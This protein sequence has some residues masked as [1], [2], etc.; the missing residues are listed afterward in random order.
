M[1]V[2]VKERTLECL[3]S[4]KLCNSRVKQHRPGQWAV[5]AGQLPAF[6]I[7]EVTITRKGCE[8]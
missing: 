8:S 4:S 3:T 6:I 2:S 5:L 1:N 7:A